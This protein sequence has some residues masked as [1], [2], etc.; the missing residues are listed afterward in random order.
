MVLDGSLPPVS[1]LTGIA[2]GLAPAYEGALNEYFRRCAAAPPCAPG[3]DPAAAFD[4]MVSEIRNDP[5]M[6]LGQGSGPFACRPP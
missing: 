6:V 5:P 3:D 4:A 1:T 2:E